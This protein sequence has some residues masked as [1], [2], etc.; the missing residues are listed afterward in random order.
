MATDEHTRI[1]W[2]AI[3]AA[4]TGM[5]A[6]FLKH[7]IGHVSKDVQYKDNCEQIHKRTDQA[8]ENMDRKLDRLLEYHM[9]K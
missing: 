6:F 2:A 8:I 3:I 1:M 4:I 5:Y 7:V 9:K